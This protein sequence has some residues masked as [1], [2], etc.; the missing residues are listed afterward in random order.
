MLRL[1]QHHGVADSSE[2]SGSEVQRARL[3]RL[4]VGVAALLALGFA[5]AAYLQFGGVPIPCVFHEITGLKCPGCGVTRMCMALLQG[6]VSAAFA[7]NPAV[8]LFLP[9]IV[10][11]GG[12]CAWRYVKTGEVRL[13]RFENAAI[14]VLIVVLVLFAVAR[15]LEGF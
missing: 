13:T 9:L 12:I 1:L 14:W 5:Y 15:N 6:K 3:R 4:L 2:P 11:E 10:V 7:A 8:F